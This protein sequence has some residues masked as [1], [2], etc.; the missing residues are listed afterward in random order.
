MVNMHYRIR[1]LYREIIRWYLGDWRYFL[2][3][4]KQHETKLKRSFY[5]DSSLDV[6]TRKTV[7]YMANGFCV[8]AGLADRLKGMTTLYG[9]CKDANVEFKI[10]HQ[11][12]F[13]LR[14]Y[15]VPN[16]Y[17]WQVSPNEICYNKKQVSVNYFMLHP[18]VQKQIDS[19]EIIA[20]E[21]E[22]SFAR[23]FTSVHNQL[24]FYTNMYPNSADSFS[25]N[26]LELFKPSRKLEKE[27][28]F[29]LKEIN[30]QFI[31]VSYRF[32]Q[33]LGDFK[34][35]EGIVLP[36]NQRED[37]IKR[38]IK[39]IREIKIKNSSIRKVFVTSDSFTFLQEAKKLPF[40]YVVE[41]KVGHINFTCSDD[42]NMKTFL[43]FFMIA[44][45][46]KVYLAKTEKMYNSEFSRRA[47]MI[48]N[49]KFEIVNY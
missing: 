5:K 32:M 18:L 1:K 14:D 44:H 19:G 3:D 23:I 7:I 13:D 8:H 24:H 26:F 2:F 6:F 4:I 15:L 39:V 29:H 28:S 22:W 45:A 40:V 47:A 46:S 38:S 41:G 42:V 9:I 30:G 43:D 27:L 10:F 12:P 34:D 37:L 35:C 21:R 16:R 20:L 17:D 11:F 48:Y 33:L 36:P 25:T 49:K 31:S